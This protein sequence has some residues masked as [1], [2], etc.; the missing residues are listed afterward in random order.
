PLAHPAP[1]C[2]PDPPAPLTEVQQNQYDAL[3]QV[4]KSWADLPTTSGKKTERVPLSADEKMWLTRECL[5]RYLRATKWNLGNASKRLQDTLVWR[6]EF[7]ADRFTADY[8]SEENATGKQIIFGYDNNA[9]P[10][11]YLLP[12]KQ[13]TKASPKQVEHLVYMLERVIEL[14]PAG[15]E[16]LALLIDFKNSSASSNPSVGMGKQVLNILQNHYPERLG[17]ALVSHIPWYVSG[18]FKLITPFIDPHTKTKLKFNEPL[19]NH[20][21]SSQLLK[22]AGGDVDFMYEH[23]VYWPAL[24]E[25]AT[26]RRREQRERWERAGG[27]VAESEGYIKGGDEPSI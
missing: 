15:Q 14:M 6:R 19:T 10:C 8:I 20:V 5:L 17:R 22:A 3:L 2:L 27:N 7:G 21:P 4:V 16:T 1:G 26:Q 11:L 25:L 12:N 24:D 9:R 13:N 23:E 18:F